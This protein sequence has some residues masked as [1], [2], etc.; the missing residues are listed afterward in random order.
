MQAR[1]TLI[2]ACQY[3]Q[4]CLYVQGGVGGGPGGCS[5][6]VCWRAGPHPST[7]PLHRPDTG[8]RQLAHCSTCTS[9]HT[10]T[11]LNIIQVSTFI[12]ARLRT[13]A[14]YTW[15]CVT[16]SSALSTCT[17]LEHT[18]PSRALIRQG[19]ASLPLYF[20]QQD[21]TFAL[22]VTAHCTLVGK[23]VVICTIYKGWGQCVCPSASLYSIVQWSSSRLKYVFRLSFLFHMWLLGLV[24]LHHPSSHKH[25][26][27]FISN[28]GFFQQFILSM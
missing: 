21:F 18:P 16:L 9:L 25:K 26:D 6:T 5:S 3:L 28:C 22:I 19:S 1:Q 20:V 2:F 7:A 8:T 4:G 13:I 12:L 17:L 23:S 24:G 11:L 10:C 14:R 27:Y 15:Y